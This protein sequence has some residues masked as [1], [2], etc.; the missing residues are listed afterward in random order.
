MAD[1]LDGK[2]DVVVTSVVA[3]VTAG[4]AVVQIM[5]DVCTEGVGTVLREV[6]AGDIAICICWLNCCGWGEDCIGCGG[7]CTVC[8]GWG[9]VAKVTPPLGAIVAG[10]WIGMVCPLGSFT[11]TCIRYCGRTGVA[12]L[13]KRQ[14]SNAT[15]SW[16]VFFLITIRGLDLSRDWTAIIL[17]I[18]RI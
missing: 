6:A 12:A 17:I 8:G 15:S 18:H 5:L 11:R 10:N 13:L 1:A 7:G 16:Q 4:G 3:M 2:L 14:T 9:T